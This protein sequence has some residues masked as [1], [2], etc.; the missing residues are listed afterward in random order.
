MARYHG[1]QHRGAAAKAREHRR[2]DARHRTADRIRRHAEDLDQA[3]PDLTDP[4]KD[5][6]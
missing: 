1:P 6:E 2:V 4:E 3:R 5:C